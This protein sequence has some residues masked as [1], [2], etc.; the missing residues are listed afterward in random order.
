M[1]WSR[2]ARLPRGIATPSQIRQTEWGSR[3]DLAG[4]RLKGKRRSEDRRA[5][6]GRLT[7][8]AYV[9]VLG[10]AWQKRVQREDSL[11]LITLD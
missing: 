4:L 10:V 3:A 5:R 7:S 11:V 9:T 8:A 6:P 2:R 1:R